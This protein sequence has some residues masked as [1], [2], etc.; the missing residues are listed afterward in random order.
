MVEMP[1]IREPERMRKL[2]QGSANLEFWETYSNQEIAPYLTQLDQRLANTDTKTDTAATDSTKKVQAKAATA[3]HLVLDRSDAD[4]GGDAQ[5]A[6]LKKMHPLL[7][8]LQTIPGES[9][10]LVGYA[11]VRDT[12]AVNRLSMVSL[13]SRFCQAT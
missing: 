6:A 9:L 12:A 1:G 13:L 5:M 11:S 2:L 7:S 3:K 10:S 8:M 4:K